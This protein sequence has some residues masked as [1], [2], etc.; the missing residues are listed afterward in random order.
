MKKKL[1]CLLL[2]FCFLFCFGSL[3]AFAEESVTEIRSADDFK[4][5]LRNGGN[6]ILINSLIL[7]EEDISIRAHGTV[8]LELGTNILSLD[9]CQ[10]QI[11]G[12]FIV[13]CSEPRCPGMLHFT[14][15]KEAESFRLS[16]KLI[17]NHVNLTAGIIEGTGTI[18]PFS[19]H[20]SFESFDGNIIAFN[21]LAFEYGNPHCLDPEIFTEVFENKNL[22]P[23]QTNNAKAEK[24]LDENHKEVTTWTDDGQS[25]YYRPVWD[26]SDSPVSVMTASEFGN[27]N[28]WPLFTTLFAG[29]TIVFAILYLKEKKK[30]HEK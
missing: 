7:S 12:E 1:I 13:S 9:K 21:D 17:L 6:G 18:Y 11:A 5:L 20:A 8:H 30:K 15:N 22:I 14:G 19:C 2:S 28:L 3:S 26:F 10:F 23:I 29:G 4:A 27:S 25:H 16:G 24:W